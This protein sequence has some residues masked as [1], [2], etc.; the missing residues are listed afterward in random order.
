MKTLKKQLFGYAS[1]GSALFFER[2]AGLASETKPT[3]GLVSGSEYLEVN[4]GREFV[5]DAESDT[6]AWTERVYATAEVTPSEP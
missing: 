3:A 2:I 5:L 6:K 1:D 4:T